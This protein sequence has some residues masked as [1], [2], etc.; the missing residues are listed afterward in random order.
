MLFYYIFLIRSALE[1][2]KFLYLEV[3]FFFP[4]PTKT[5]KKTKFIMRNGANLISVKFKGMKF[6][7]FAET[8]HQHSSECLNSHFSFQVNFSKLRRLRKTLKY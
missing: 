7:N 5:G 8:E 1:R 4:F 6:K 2:D 3:G